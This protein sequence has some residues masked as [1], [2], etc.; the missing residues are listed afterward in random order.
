M[1]Q[2]TWNYMEH[3]APL[4]SQSDQG[5]EFKRSVKRLTKR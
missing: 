4:V 1:E 3:G 2:I 5:T